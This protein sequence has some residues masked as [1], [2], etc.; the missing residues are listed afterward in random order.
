VDEFKETNILGFQ[1]LYIKPSLFYTPANHIPSNFTMCSCY[2]CFTRPEVRPSP[3]ISFL[4]KLFWGLIQAKVWDGMAES[5]DLVRD[6]RPPEEAPLIEKVSTIESREWRSEWKAHL[7][8]LV[9]EIGM[10]R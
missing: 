6:N 1:L 8:S 4:V 5:T 10:P 9:S 3:L 7:G 2:C